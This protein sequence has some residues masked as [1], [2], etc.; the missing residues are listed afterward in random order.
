MV[1]TTIIWQFDFS[2]IPQKVKGETNH[3]CSRAVIDL[4]LDKK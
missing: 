1:K 4:K 3:V 2:F